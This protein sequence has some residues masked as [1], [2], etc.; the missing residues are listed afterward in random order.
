M[1]KTACLSLPGVNSSA[2]QWKNWHQA[3]KGCVGK[4]N[5]NQLFTQQYDKVGYDS[6]TELRSYMEAQGVQLDRDALD[7]LTDTGMGVYNWAGGAFNFASGVGTIVVVMVL[8]AVGVLLYKMAQDPDT[9]VR[10]GSAVATKGKSEM[11]TGGGG[12]KKIGK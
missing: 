7:R 3:L 12:M 6:T 8:G 4:T 5:A 1:N 2:A 9:A 10:V 11:I